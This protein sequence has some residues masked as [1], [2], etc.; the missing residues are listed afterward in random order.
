MANCLFRL[1]LI[2]AFIF[3][4]SLN[5]QESDTVLLRLFVEDTVDRYEHARSFFDNNE[6]T[7]KEII[8]IAKSHIEALDDRYEFLFF[9]DEYF[10]VRDPKISLKVLRE[11]TAIAQELQDSE[12]EV[13]AKV[14]VAGALQYIGDYDSALNTYLKVLDEVPEGTEIYY[15]I[16]EGIALTYQGLDDLI[17]AKSY[18]QKV[19]KYFRN[20]KNSHN[21]YNTIYNYGDL[22][23]DIGIY[24]SSII[25]FEEVLDNF[26]VHERLD[27]NS[28]SKGQIARAHEL[29][30]NYREAITWQRLGLYEEKATKSYSEMI[31]SHG[32]LAAAF[33]GLGQIDSANYHFSMALR[34]A[35]ELKVYEKMLSTYQLQARVYAKAEYFEKAYKAEKRSSMLADSL[36]GIQIQEVQ[37]ELREKYETEKK[38]AENELLIKQNNEQRFFL[39]IVACLFL[40]AVGTL[41]FI[42]RLQKKTQRLNEKISSQSVQLNQL[43]QTKDRL[44]SIISHDLRGPIS[45]FE[46]VASLVQNFL[47]K[48]DTQKVKEIVVKVEKS[49]KNLRMLLDN[50]LN[51][52]LSQQ[53]GITLKVKSLDLPSL[54]N[55]VVDTLTVSAEAK[56]IKLN[57]EIENI[58]AE[59]DYDT[60]TTALR[61]LISNAIKF[62]PIGSSIT[63]GA[64]YEEEEILIQVSDQGMGIPP[65][66]LNKMFKVDKS[67]VRK[68]TAREE[69]TGLGLVLVKEFVEMNHGKVSVA[70]TEGEGSTFTIHLPVV[71]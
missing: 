25:I 53:G 69:G 61:N 27:L 55:E 38:E 31:D 20:N 2:S 65:T 40:I 9:A 6:L 19:L 67:K 57:Q 21:Y 11:A 51:W 46:S 34:Y 62:S 33:T 59:A 22:L 23:I 8:V 26:N 35:E 58:T 64:Q 10:Y 63:I 50:L 44:F 4:Y 15:D 7:A 3:S 36:K 49:S 16:L 47:N 13:F 71:N 12:R 60:L 29:Q 45:A 1:H 48:G 66:Q 17:L 28:S 30:G 14:N 32:T 68:G 5:A 52:S 43:N 41:I 18:F 56:E 70:S 37:L 42:Y 24:D 54:I 39:V